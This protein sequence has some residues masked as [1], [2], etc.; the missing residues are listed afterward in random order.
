[1]AAGVRIVAHQYAV[2]DTFDVFDVVRTNDHI[3]WYGIATRKFIP[4]RGKIE[5][6]Y[7]VAKDAHAGSAATEGSTRATGGVRFN[8]IEHVNQSARQAV[9]HRMVP[10]MVPMM[11]QSRC[12][13]QKGKD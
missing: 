3:A 10:V 5:T 1:V 13:E 7:R 11:G 9:D 2:L 12:C 6:A 4:V 8:R